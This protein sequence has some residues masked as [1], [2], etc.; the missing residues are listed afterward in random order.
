M[1]NEYESYDSIADIINMDSRYKLDAY[2]F[3]MLV[4]DKIQESLEVQRHISGEDVLK[5][6]KSV[7]SE[8]YGPMAKE[9]L[10]SW[11]VYKT[12]DIGNI[13]FSLVEA[14]LL[15][16]TEKDSIEDFVERFDFKKVFE[17][18]YFDT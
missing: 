10:N 2:S 14:G 4:I 17:E 15:A 13:V 3:V 5:G 18:D 11:G 7:A 6:I 1:K 12:E 16:K 9:V 8:R